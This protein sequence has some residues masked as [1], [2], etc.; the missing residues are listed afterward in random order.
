MVE[1]RRVAHRSP[2]QGTTGSSFGSTSFLNLPAL[3]VRP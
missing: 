1:K 2:L 3:V